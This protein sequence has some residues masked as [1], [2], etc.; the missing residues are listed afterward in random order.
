[1]DGWK[2]LERAVES[3]FLSELHAKLLDWDIMEVAQRKAFTAVKKNEGG[4]KGKPTAGVHGEPPA[5]PKVFWRYS[6]LACS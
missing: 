5:L 3:E 1:M 2:R 4:K 6:W